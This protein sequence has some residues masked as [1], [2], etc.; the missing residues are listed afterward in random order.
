VGDFAPTAGLDC[1]I[2]KAFIQ[3]LFGFV[4]LAHLLVL[5]RAAPSTLNTL[6]NFG[7]N[8]PHVELIYAS[9][10]ISSL[11]FVVCGC[12]KIADPEINS[13]GVGTLYT[14]VWCV[15]MSWFFTVVPHY[16]M[17]QIA[18]LRSSAKTAAQQRRVRINELVNRASK[19][20]S[21]IVTPGALLAC[22]VPLLILADPGH[23][24]VYAALHYIGILPVLLTLYF[25]VVRPSLEWMLDDFAVSD[26]NPAVLKARKRLAWLKD[27]GF[28]QCVS[29]VVTA[30]MMGLWPFFT[31][32]AT[33]QLGVVWVAA[34]VLSHII[35]TVLVVR[36]HSA[37]VGRGS[38]SAVSVTSDRS[39]FSSS[40]SRLP[41]TAMNRVAVAVAESARR[42]STAV[43]PA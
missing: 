42:L 43:A 37:S 2:N 35:I 34:S 3:G 29:N 28:R 26:G 27:E 24:A 14:V 15:G 23:A 7:R 30:S 20:M 12:L 18:Y 38:I 40:P 4:A 32:K 8:K 5:V 10:N 25:V 21:Y 22:N 1:G 41:S 13:I 33:Y 11:C 19:T 16:V 39:S 36:R 17:L 31:C 9:L 6:R